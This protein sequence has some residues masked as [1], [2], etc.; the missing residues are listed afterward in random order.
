MAPPVRATLDPATIEAWSAIVATYRK[1]YGRSY[2]AL[3][4]VGL[5][6]VGLTLWRH[7]PT[8]ALGA[9]GC[10]GLGRLVNMSGRRDIRCPHCGESPFLSAKSPDVDSLEWCERCLYW[11]KRPY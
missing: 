4:G 2:A 7:D 10:L 11:L 8:I 3:T 1:R 5:V 9:G 6:C